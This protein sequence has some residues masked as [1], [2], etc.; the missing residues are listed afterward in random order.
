[1]MKTAWIGVLD[2]SPLGPV[3]VAVSEAG[4][5]AVEV[6][7][8]QQAVEAAARRLGFDQVLL[9]RERTA[10]AVSQIGEYL[11]G[12]RRFFDLPL[13][14]SVLAHSNKMHCVDLRDPSGEALH[15]RDR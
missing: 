8:D 7:T 9:D 12:V 15:G 14:W 6:D 11:S 3:W 4:L 5:V 10:G 2:T 1:M 13:D